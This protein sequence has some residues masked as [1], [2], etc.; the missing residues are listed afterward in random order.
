MS[1]SSLS[2][3][4]SQMDMAALLSYTKSKV[5]QKNK[6]KLP[7]FLRHIDKN[8]D[9]NCIENLCAVSLEDYL[10][11]PDWQVD[12]EL[13]VSRKDVVKIEARMYQLKALNDNSSK[14]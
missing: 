5:L 4:V 7:I 12:L 1:T 2:D 10:K 11:N 14:K 6:G 9:N 13:Y 3:Q 8:T